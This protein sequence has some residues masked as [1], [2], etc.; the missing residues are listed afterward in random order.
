MFLSCPYNLPNLLALAILTAPASMATSSGSTHS[1]PTQQMIS[2]C[3]SFA[4][5]LF[6][7]SD[8]LGD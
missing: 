5:E 3:S 6:L 7:S 8:K 2:R 1:P 4:E